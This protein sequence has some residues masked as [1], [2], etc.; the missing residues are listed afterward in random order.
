LPEAPVEQIAKALVNRGLIW[1]ERGESEK[2]VADYTKVIEGLPE[3]PVEQIAQAL[4]N[5][6]W[7]LYGGDDF[8][9]FLADS[10]LAL[11]KGPI[12]EAAAFNLVWRC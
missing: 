7:C 12:L 10:E 6:G 11:S 9:G 1:N 4:V 2:E 8:A 5:R 3:A